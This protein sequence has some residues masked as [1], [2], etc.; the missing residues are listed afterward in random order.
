MRKQFFVLVLIAVGMIACNKSETTSPVSQNDSANQTVNLSEIPTVVSNYVLENY[1]DASITAFEKTSLVS[2]AYVVTLTTAEQITFDHNGD[3][4]VDGHHFGHGQGIPVDSLPSSI[5]AY[6]TGQYAAYT[7]RHARYDTLCQ[8]GPVIAVI[9]SQDTLQP[10]KL[11]FDET[12]SFAAVANRMLTTE[13]PAVVTDFVAVSYPEYTLRTKAEK[14]TLA[15]NSI[16]YKAFLH[17][18]SL[19]FSVVVAADGTLV[20]EGEVHIG[21]HDGG[22]HH[23]GGHHGGGG[24]DGGH[25]GGGHHGGIPVDSLSVVISDYV[26][27]NYSAYTIKNAR[28]DSL[29][30]LGDVIK[31]QLE[32]VDNNH[33]S[34]FFDLTNVYLAEADRMAVAD[35]PLAV[36]DAITASYAEYHTGPFATQFILADGAL[37]YGVELIK[38]HGKINVVFLADGSVVCVN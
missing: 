27:A 9:I 23:G 16:Q 35:L 19:G 8:F 14:F 4:S 33:L 18:D 22:G 7:I 25:H 3:R 38:H 6:I 21:G 29:C 1:P 30:Q 17:A 10:L 13:L 15:D 20:C 37:H 32:D 31:L 24:H 5:T 12:N 28:Y 11:I 34:L 36:T 26:T 2:S